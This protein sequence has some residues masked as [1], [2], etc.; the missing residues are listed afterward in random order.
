MTSIEHFN[1]RSFDLNL[2][3]AFDAL[4]NEGSVTQAAR[5]LKIQQPAMSH[6]LSTLRLLMQDELFVRVGQLMQ[7][8]AKARRLASPVRQALLM[9]QR[10]L[11]DATIF[12]PKLDERRF[13]IVMTAEAEALLLPGLV[14]RAREQGPG[15]KIMLETVPRSAMETALQDGVIDLAIGCNY[16]G[17]SQ[18]EV[19]TLYDI[20]AAACFNPSLLDLQV[21]LSPEAFLGS[22]LAFASEDES[23]HRYVASVLALGDEA[24]EVTLAT[25]N[26]I[27]ALAAAQTSPVIAT[28]CSL[29]AARFAP[30]LGLAIS[31]VPLALDLPPVSMVWARHADKDPANTWLR[32]QVRWVNSAALEARRTE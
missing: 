30:A 23:L 5:R 26:F 29:L 4:M 27:S 25:H 15:M 16:A 21:P 7:P 28:V 17:T 31:E 24:P 19:E 12:D 13:R 11:H 3:V 8:T 32:E 20:K 6:S 1:L 18:T 2:L 10:A 14:A 9:A 22:K